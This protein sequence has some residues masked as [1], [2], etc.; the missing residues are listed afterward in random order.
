M[1]SRKTIVGLFSACFM[2]SAVL[3]VYLF[4]TDKN[5]EYISGLMFFTLVLFALALGNFVVYTMEKWRDRRKIC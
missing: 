4:S 3:T 1:K 2:V 5:S